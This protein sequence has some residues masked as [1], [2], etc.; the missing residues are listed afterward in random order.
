MQRRSSLRIWVAAVVLAAGV[1]GT[2]ISAER[3]SSAMASAA[4]KLL[5]SLTPEQ[6][7][8]A[9][10]AFASDERTHWHF[11]PTDM[12]PRNGLT[13]KQMTDPQRRLAHDLLK[14]GLSQCGYLTATS[15]MDLE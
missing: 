10:F 1:A 7:Q 14:T 11:I 2:L 6:R 5:A 13:I 9:A 3:S 15:I 4:A 12:F 8:Q